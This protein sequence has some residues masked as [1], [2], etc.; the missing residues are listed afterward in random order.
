MSVVIFH[1]YNSYNYI[2]FQRTLYIDVRT[3][4]RV[5]KLPEKINKFPMLRQITVIFI[6]IGAC[7]PGAVLVMAKNA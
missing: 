3:F 7:R 2:I 6:I 1:Y 5:I 4:H